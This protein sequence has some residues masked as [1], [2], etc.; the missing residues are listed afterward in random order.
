MPQPTIEILICTID[1][2]IDAAPRVPID[3]LPNVRY[4][5][6]WQQTNEVALHQ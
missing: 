6:C 4:L 1:N 2:R 5:V 3:P